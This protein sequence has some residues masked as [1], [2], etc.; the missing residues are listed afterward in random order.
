MSVTDNLQSSCS[1]TIY[2]TGRT[3]AGYQFAPMFFAPTD[4]RAF[5][6]YQGTNDH[7]DLQEL[8]Y[9]TDWEVEVRSSYL[10]G[11]KIYLSEEAVSGHLGW[12]L[13]VQRRLPL[14]QELHMSDIQRL[15]IAQ[16]EHSLDLA[17]LRD[18]QMQEQLDRCAMIPPGKEG[19]SQSDFF[20]DFKRLV[21]NAETW[22]G[23]AEQGAH[24]AQIARN[25]AQGYAQ[26]ALNAKTSAQIARSGAE[27]ARDAAAA[28]AA[29]AAASASAASRAERYLRFMAMAA[30]STISLDKVGA[31]YEVFLDYSTD[32]K[33]WT[34][35]SWNSAGEGETITLA[36]PRDYVMFRGNNVRF[37]KGTVLSGTSITD[38]YRFSMSGSITA[39]GSIMSLLDQWLLR[40]WLPSPY[41]FACLFE[42]CTALTVAPELPATTLDF[43]CY[44]RMFAGSGILTTPY[45]PA[46]DLVRG[47]YSSM[48]EG[49]PSLKYAL[50]LPAKKLADSCYNSMFKECPSLVSAPDLPAMELAEMC[51]AYMFDH[52]TSL[53]YAPRL[54]STELASQCYMAMFQRCTSLKQVEADFTAFGTSSETLYWLY[55][56]SASGRFIG[57]SGLTIASRGVSTV[58][59]GWS[60]EY[61]VVRQE[62][63]LG[64]ET[65]ME[66]S[67]ASSLQVSPGH[68]YAWTPS[69]N[70]TLSLASGFSSGKEAYVSLTVSPGTHSVTLSSDF[71]S[72][73]SDTLSASKKNI[74]VIRWDGSK[75]TLYKCA[76]V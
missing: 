3:G 38:Y 46:M 26:D 54:P 8:D 63:F 47:C 69:A 44:W 67:T 51:Y 71:D 76:E 37:S 62:E 52:C 20:M 61:T 23:D 42:D 73:H 24:D 30:N 72:A 2:G 41:V 22:V 65:D 14:S 70:A 29:A 36:Y 27:T 74:C 31:P 12:T 17:A 32:G 49:C 16:L 57:W 6:L 10:E 43:D 7:E 53:E 50:A 28:S 15:P 39:S 56:V 25:A 60:V 59:T 9:G 75:A 48:F 5:V 66:S 19:Y 40:S 13:T 45:L 11:A 55:G 64:G 68:A 4:L 21:D 34:P 33:T 35:Y 58:P 1:W 18:Q